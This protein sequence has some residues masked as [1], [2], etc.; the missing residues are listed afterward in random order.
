MDLLQTILEDYPDP[1]L[2]ARIDWLAE[3]RAHCANGSWKE[4]G[5]LLA[6]G[7]KT[8]KQ[9]RTEEQ[10]MKFVRDFFFDDL[11]EQDRYL[12]AS[13][14]AWSRGLF[15]QRPAHIKQ[16]FDALQKE[17]LVI[18]L[19]AS[20]LSKTYSAAAFCSLDFMRDPENTSVKF[21]SVND[22]NLK[23]NLWSN[24]RTFQEQCLFP[25]D[26]HP[27][28]TRMR[29]RP[30]NARPD[31]GVDA[32][33]FSKQKDS[34]GKI[35]GFHPKPFRL[36]PH[37][38]Y[39]D[40]TVVR[41]LLDETQELSP[42]VQSDLG[43]PMS[44]IEK[45]QGHMKIIL[46]GNP[47]DEGKWVVQMAQPPGGWEEEKIDDLKEWKA[48]GWHVVRLDGADF[49]NVKYSQ[50]IFPAF[51]PEPLMMP[52]N[53][54]GNRPPIGI[55]SVEVG[56]RPVGPRRPSFPRHGSITPRASPHSSARLTGSWVG[57]SPSSMTRR[58]SR[59]VDTEWRR[60]IWTG[61]APSIG[62]S[63]ASTRTSSRTDTVA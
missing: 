26:L 33:L 62:S 5:K 9:I 50:T 46:T 16:I 18:L 39:G 40:L 28:E 8:N 59:S 61:A 37:P 31:C 44:T 10:A 47:I 48:N 6:L 1:E 53:T 56:P 35:K 38:K 2:L 13:A 45:G 22:T 12:E 60:G 51:S 49:E 19:G 3:V 36:K 52:I 23:G 11:L 32:V 30:M 14:L 21:G 42:G 29:M 58:S 20:G 41:I 24:L 15:E 54:M 34:T 27:N 17:D 7:A 57:I 25:R 63:V 43:S 55:S 4:G